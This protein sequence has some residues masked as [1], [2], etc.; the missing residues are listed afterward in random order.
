MFVRQIAYVRVSRA[1]ARMG[2]TPRRE[3]LRRCYLVRVWRRLAPVVSAAEPRP[4]ADHGGK[5]VLYAGDWYPS[6]LQRDRES[7]EGYKEIEK[8]RERGIGKW[9]ERER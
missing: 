9:R 6:V 1:C 3:I 7:K 2:R 8:E 5:G 4:G